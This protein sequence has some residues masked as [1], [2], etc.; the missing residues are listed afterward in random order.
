M[1]PVGGKLRTLSGSASTI[2]PDGTLIALLPSR[3]QTRLAETATGRTRQSYVG[4]VLGFSPDGRLVATEDW[5]RRQSLVRIW[6]TTS[7][8]LVHAL[9]GHSGG[10]V[11]ESGTFSP[12]GS[13]LL[14]EVT[15]IAETFVWDVVGGRS[16][17]R[18]T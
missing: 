11:V 7:G 4:E 18:F 16:I 12:D 14:T 10:E 3:N 15:R 13:Q 2:S 8:H 1:L 17:R 6:E 9:R 5:D